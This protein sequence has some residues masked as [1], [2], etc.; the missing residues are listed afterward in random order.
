M[1]FGIF[2]ENITANIHLQKRHTAKKS[3]AAPS[4]QKT[5]HFNRAERAY[6]I[7]VRGRQTKSSASAKHGGMKH[8]H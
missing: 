5:V 3:A 1:K 2:D 8:G 6:I 7:G 4:G